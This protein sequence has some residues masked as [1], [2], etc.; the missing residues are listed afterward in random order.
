M[1]ATGGAMVG[2]FPRRRRYRQGAV[3]PD[4]KPPVDDFVPDQAAGVATMLRELDNTASA[5]LHESGPFLF[6]A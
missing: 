1:I 2:A 3:R 5:R 4:K 6:L